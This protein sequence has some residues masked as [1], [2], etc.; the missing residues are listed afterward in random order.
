MT[1]RPYQKSLLD[2]FYKKV[3]PGFNTLMV[4]PT[5]GG[6]TYT[7]CTALKE[8]NLPTCV[9]AHRHNLV[10]QMSLQLGRM[11]V[12][13]RLICSDKSL[14][15]ITKA[16]RIHLG[17]VWFDPTAPVVCASVDTMIRRPT[18][19]FRNIKFWITD[20]AH[21]LLKKN[22]WGRAI[23]ML[24]KDCIGLGVTATPMR[25]DGKGLGAHA[26]GFFHDMIIGPSGQQLIDDGY[27]SPYE[28]A[29]INVDDLDFS[30]V[31]HGSDG[32]FKLTQLR[33]ATKRSRILVGSMVK[34]Y[35]KRSNGKLALTF[36]VDIEHAEKTLEQ[37]QE[38]GIPSGIITGKTPILQQVET[39]RKFER[40]E[41]L[42]LVSV[43]MFGE[44]VDIP[45]VNTVLLGRKTDSFPLFAQQVG[46]C[47]RPVY[48]DGFD[49]NTREG[50]KAAI[51][52]GPKPKALVLDFVGNVVPRHGV[53]T[54]AKQYTLDA[55]EKR[56]RQQPLS[57]DEKLKA[58]A[59][60]DCAKAYPAFMDACPFCGRRPQVSKGTSADVKEVDG[61]L[62]LLSVEAV[63][64]LTKETERIMRPPHLPTNLPRH[65]IMAI[66][67]RHSARADAQKAL[68]DAISLW[69]G[70][71]VHKYGRSITE[72]QKLFY[73]RFGIDVLTAQTLGAREADELR[74]KVENDY[75]I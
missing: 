31:E 51:A 63:E 53:P 34:E 40:G 8:L 72:A 58:C 7:F 10:G 39:M 65:V 55:R 17:K 9:I 62:T 12:P 60:E 18:T 64:A 56:E 47:L 50:R 15:E 61:D 75:N 69:G 28:C 43:D 45:S 74:E 16:H 1:L 6:K 11:Q 5:G 29:I 46:R 3:K 67:K 24:P 54:A 30:D 70:V 19:I 35:R 68:R 38:A 32:D 44:G 14:L 41:I 20:E 66:I 59:Y 71:Q 26:D 36:C 23:D 73:I 48:A 42:N 2:E 4:L 27:L 13:H 57:E 52:A 49:L 25:A 33:T 37:F 22:K 21:H